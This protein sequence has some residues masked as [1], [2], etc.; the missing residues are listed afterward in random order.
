MVVRRLSSAMVF[1]PDSWS[2]TSRLSPIWL[3]S[4]PG[5]SK[6]EPE[7]LAPATVANF[8]NLAQKGYYNGVRFHR[9]VP[10]FVAQTGDPTGTGYGGP[11]HTIRCEVT[12]ASY[13]R[14]TVGMA[15]AGPDTGGSQ[16]FIVSG[17]SGVGLPPA[18]SLFGQVVKGLEI[19]DQMQGVAT[20]RS[21]RPHDDV[22]IN[23]VEITECF[24][25]LPAESGFR[26]WARK[27]PENFIFPV[28][29]PLILGLV[30]FPVVIES[31]DGQLATIPSSR[32][33]R[34]AVR[35]SV[36]SSQ[37]PMA[38]RSSARTKT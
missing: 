9:V 38:A 34:G 8:L 12:D 26:T 24:E 14:G 33:G 15:L 30:C 37:C 3:F 28:I 17:P 13:E 16:F 36:P 29:I 11:G 31:P 22:V 1:A 23:S 18:Y 21:D 25:R 20:D 19:V 35:R 4:P 6:F 32:R 27:T 2:W 5:S 10:G 7:M